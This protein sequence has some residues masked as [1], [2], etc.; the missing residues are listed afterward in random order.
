MSDT[1]NARVQKLDRQ[2][3]VL[4]VI[5][6]LGETLGQMVRPK[7][8]AVDRAGRL[9]VADAATDSVQIFDPDGRLLL[10]LGGPGAGRATCRCRPKSP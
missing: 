9:Y 5:G 6:S 3:H 8:I 10:M 1:L 7:G 4:Q 2:G